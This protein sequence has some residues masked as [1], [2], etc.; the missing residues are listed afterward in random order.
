MNDR[1]LFISWLYNNEMYE[2]SDC[3]CVGALEA[4]DN[5]KEA[6]KIKEELMMVYSP[7]PL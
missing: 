2:F 6:W 5:G 7:Y 3:S 1:D 4:Y